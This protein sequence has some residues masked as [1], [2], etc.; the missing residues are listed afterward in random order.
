MRLPSVVQISIANEMAS[1]LI[2]FLRACFQ[3]EIE[4]F[5]KI[6]D[7]LRDSTESRAT[8]VDGVLRVK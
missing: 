8:V 2:E 6:K 4:L 7:W 3:S 5:F 1:L